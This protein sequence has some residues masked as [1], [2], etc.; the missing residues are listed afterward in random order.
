MEVDKDVSEKFGR[1]VVTS[2]RKEKLPQEKGSLTYLLL[3][4][5][6]QDVRCTE[7]GVSGLE[8]LSMQ[9][10]EDPGRAGSS[11]SAALSLQVTGIQNLQSAL[12]GWDVPQHRFLYF[13]GLYTPLT[14]GQRGNYTQLCMFLPVLHGILLMP[15]KKKKDI[16]FYEETV[17]RGNR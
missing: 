1:N 2:D 10:Y 4:W 17:S 3:S 13:Y 5:C 16:L 9:M 7:C 8:P 14:L 15:T 11:P 6:S 12:W